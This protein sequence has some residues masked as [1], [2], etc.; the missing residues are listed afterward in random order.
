MYPYSVYFILYLCVRIEQ[1]RVYNWIRPDPSPFCPKQINFL[2]TKPISFNFSRLAIELLS[3]LEHC[4]CVRGVHNTKFFFLSLVRSRQYPISYYVWQRCL[5]LNITSSG[6]QEVLVSW[7]FT[8]TNTH[9]G[10]SHY[11][12]AANLSTVQVYTAI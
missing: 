3:L 6:F 12:K 9:E 1:L 8:F 2:R 10:V 5:L 4:D 7:S 11:E